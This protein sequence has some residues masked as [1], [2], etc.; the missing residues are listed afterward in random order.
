MDIIINS[1]N[2]KQLGYLNNT[3]IKQFN[4]EKNL[5]I[6]FSILN[7]FVREPTTKKDTCLEVGKHLCMCAC[8]GLN[9]VKSL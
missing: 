7:F 3:K 2:D 6:Q 8:M 1:M 4:V 9:V 5:S